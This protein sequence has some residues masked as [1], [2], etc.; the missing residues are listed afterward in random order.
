MLRKVYEAD[1]GGAG[2]SADEGTP[3]T[4]D[5]PT[6]DAITWEAVLAGLTDEAKTLYQDHTSGLTSALDKE[7]DA[8]KDQ[9]KSLRDLAKQAEAGSDAQK[10]LTEIADKLVT[11]TKR[12]DFFQE[13]AKPEIGCRSTKAA[14]TLALADDL[15]DKRGNVNWTALKESYPELFGVTP[16]PT[17]DAGAGRNTGIAGESVDDRIRKAAHR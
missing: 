5:T 7:R 16:K 10:Q 14:F 4:P 12:A 3:P 17:A 11:E 13:A 15:F 6:P 2:S 9:E 1:K 8:R